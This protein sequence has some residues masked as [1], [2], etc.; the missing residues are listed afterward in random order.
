[1]RD[2]KISRE[3]IK[4][5]HRTDLIKNNDFCVDPF[6]ENN[7]LFNILNAY[8]F[9]DKEVGYGQGMNMIASYLLNFTR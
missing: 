2:E 9:F 4:D 5:L 7:P 6:I 3:I 1:M 8:A